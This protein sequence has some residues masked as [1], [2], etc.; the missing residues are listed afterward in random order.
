MLCKTRMFKKSKIGINHFFFILFLAFWVLFLSAQCSQNCFENLL[1]TSNQKEKK[2]QEEN[3]KKGEQGGSLTYPIV[4]TGQTTCYDNKGWRIHAP[5]QGARFY[6]QDAQYNG[7][8]PNYRDNGD[9]T[10]SDLN[11]GLMWQKT[12][13]FENLR[14]LDEALVYADNLTLA[15]Y[16]DWRVPNIKELYSLIAFYGSIFS[17]SPY[18]D[19]NYFDFQ[20]PEPDTGLRG[21]D[22]QYL[23]STRYVAQAMY[24]NDA[25]FGVNFADGRIK[26]YPSAR[27]GN[28]PS[29]A[30]YVRCVRGRTDYGKNDFVDNGD[31]TITDRATG[32][33]W[34]KSD[35]GLTY[36]WEEA[37]AYSENLVYAGYDDWRL[38]NAK[39]LQSIVDYT[40]S[41]AADDPALRTAAID[42]IFDVTET[43]SWYWTGT[44]HGDDFHA[45]V[46]VCFGRGL[47]AIIWHG[48]NM[49]AHGAGCQRSDP[50]SGDPG[51]W[52]Y[53]RGPQADQIRIYNYVRCVRK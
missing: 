6:G 1:N 28:G 50:K 4:D 30:R 52:P 12:P 26:A 9:G 2:K 38:P 41:P 33:M 11:T 5:N 19:T 46:Y 21:M 51:K 34:M 45:A 27:Y 47:S 17:W 10:I 18:L 49:D 20:Y 29:I 23:S 16:N 13:D 53:G 36:N 43:E 24:G 32:L 44:T 8:Q 35:S 39:E 40:R 37:L 3:E 25:A 48:D 31:G 15:G 22:A 7:I 42:P 14:T